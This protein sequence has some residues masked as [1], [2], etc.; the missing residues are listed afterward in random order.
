M[1]NLSG[2]PA[3]NF[4]VA[5]GYCP[6]DWYFNSSNNTGLFYELV[7]KQGEM[8]ADTKP[9]TPL[10]VWLNGGPVI[11]LKKKKYETKKYKINRDVQAKGVL[12]ENWDLS[13]PLL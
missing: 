7:S 3:T 11:L 5:T 6:L 10:V 2:G 1:I 12:L 13:N 8:I 9:E 4:E